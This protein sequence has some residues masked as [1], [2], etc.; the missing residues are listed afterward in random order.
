MSQILFLASSPTCPVEDRYELDPRN[1]MLD[2]LREV[3]THE[4]RLLFIASSP[5]EPEGNRYYAGSVSRAFTLAGFTVAQTAILERSTASDTEALLAQS[6]V[7]FLAGG[8]VPT[9]NAF[10][11]D[12]GLRE[13]IRAFHG[14]IMGCSAGTMNAADVVY[15]APELSGEATDPDYKRF[16]P[17]L[18]LTKVQIFPH[19]QYYR[20]LTLD[21][22]R[23]LEDIAFPDSFGNPIWALPDGSYLFRNG[24]HEEIRGEAYIIRDGGLH[25][26]GYASGV[27]NP[28]DF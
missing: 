11:R 19:F 24:D 26:V 7:I 21:G 25:Q 28:A 16:I 8:H 20:D 9:Q 23:I 12:I 6:N 3:I 22:L 1:G 10:F 13:K 4:I 18:G 2:S 5:D 27:L 15:A 14:V 17:G